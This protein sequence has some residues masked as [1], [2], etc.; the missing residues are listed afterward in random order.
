V[1]RRLIPLTTLGILTIV[2][3]AFTGL[4]IAQSIS[5]PSDIRIQKSCSDAFVQRPSTLVLYCA[6]GNDE[7]THLKWEDWGD[8]TAYATGIDH[9]NDCTPTCV[10]GTQKSEPVTVWVWHIQ[11]DL[12]TSIYTEPTPRISS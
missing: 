12:Y 3:L 4:S 11:H 9:Y 5:H 1:Q 10:A 7:I 8:T 6:D 2:A